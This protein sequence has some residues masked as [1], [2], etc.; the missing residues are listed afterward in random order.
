MLV[1]VLYSDDLDP[2]FRSVSS[3]VFVEKMKKKGQTNHNSFDCGVVLI[4][5]V[6]QMICI[7][8]CFG[9]LNSL[10]FRIGIIVMVFFCSDSGVD[11]EFV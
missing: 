6:L 9:F 11:A 7:S 3:V 1:S 5:S 8:W 2:C 4:I 10:H